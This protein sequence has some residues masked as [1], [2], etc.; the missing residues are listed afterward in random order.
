MKIHNAKLKRGHD[1]YQTLGSATFFNNVLGYC[2]ILSLLPSL[3]ATLC[4]NRLE[5]PHALIG[6]DVVILKYILSFF[7][8]NDC[9]YSWPLLSSNATLQFSNLIIPYPCVLVNRSSSAE[10]M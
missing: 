3:E 9:A 8:K 6:P 1:P 7:I 10:N 4:N 2:F 5:R